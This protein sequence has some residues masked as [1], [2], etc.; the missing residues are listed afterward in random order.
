MMTWDNSWKNMKSRIGL[1]RF[2]SLALLFIF[3]VVVVV[4]P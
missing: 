4:V 1:K 3:V 2:P